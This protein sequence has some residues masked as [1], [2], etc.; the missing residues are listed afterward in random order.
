MSSKYCAELRGDLAHRRLDVA[1]QGR[2]ALAAG[3]DQGEEGRGVLRAE[4]PPPLWTAS[5]RASGLAP[6]RRSRGR[7]T[8]PRTCVLGPRRPV[9]DGRVVREPEHAAA[10]RLAA[11]DRCTGVEQAVQ[12]RAVGVGAGPADR[13]ALVAREAERLEGRRVGRDQ[14]DPRR[15]AAGDA[16]DL[17]VDV[18]PASSGLAADQARRSGRRL[19]AAG[20][21][22]Q[23][24]PGRPDR[25]PVVDQLRPPSR[26]PADSGTRS[27]RSDAARSRISS[28]AR[29]DRLGIAEEGQDRRRPSSPGASVRGRSRR[30]S[31]NR[32]V[33]VL[34]ASPASWG[35]SSGSNP[36]TYSALSTR[37]FGRPTRWSAPAT[38][39]TWMT[40]GRTFPLASA[41]PCGSVTPRNSPPGPR[42]MT[43]RTGLGSKSGSSTSPSRRAR[44]ASSLRIMR[45]PLAVLAAAASAAPR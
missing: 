13:G 36:R 7:R 30:Y 34:R 19:V 23:R 31:A 26:R 11:W 21:V 15:R 35:L 17:G 4:T 14:G 43:Q 42:L 10:Q 32:P 20:G 8:R 3:D 12:G 22:P 25:V 41:W 24:L 5:N 39:G 40:L 38:L 9:D 18:G 45:H 1:A 44:S 16:L 6:R 2:P 37:K 28:I 27:G 29:A 33:V